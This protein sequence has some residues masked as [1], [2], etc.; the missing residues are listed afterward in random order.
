MLIILKPIFLQD[1]IFLIPL[2]IIFYVNGQKFQTFLSIDFCTQKNA[3]S[4]LDESACFS[5][6]WLQ[7]GLKNEIVAA[8]GYNLPQ[9]WNAFSTSLDRLKGIYCCYYTTDSMECQSYFGKG[10]EISEKSRTFFRHMQ[11]SYQLI[12]KNQFFRFLL[13]LYHIVIFLSISNRYFF[14]KLSFETKTPFFN[15]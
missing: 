4:S 6:K 8:M 12:F 9:A 2:S 15:S 14:V 1:N 11:I 7:W 5:C 13:L 3:A 10:V